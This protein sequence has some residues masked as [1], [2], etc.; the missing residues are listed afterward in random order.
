MKKDLEKD[1]IKANTKKKGVKNTK[2]DMV[3]HPP[4]YQIREGLE[5]ID[6]IEEVTDWMELKGSEAY[7]YTQLLGYILRYKK[8]NGLQDLEKARFFLNRMIDDYR[9]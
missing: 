9:D 1:G 2:V 6:I 8:K 4:H 3:N 7:R 5:V